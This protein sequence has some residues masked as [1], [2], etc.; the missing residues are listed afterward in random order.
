MD[1]FHK[2]GVWLPPSLSLL[3]N[4]RATAQ[5]CLTEAVV[6]EAVSNFAHLNSEMKQENLH[7]FHWS[8][9]PASDW[10]EFT[11]TNATLELARLARFGCWSRHQ[12][13]LAAISWWLAL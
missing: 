3:V 8:R 4:A 2:N 10:Q 13:I 12:L 9:L 11:V 7:D 6:S 1:F 5:H